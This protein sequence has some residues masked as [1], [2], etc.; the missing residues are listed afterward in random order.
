MSFPL[1]IDRPA[2]AFVADNDSSE[3]DRVRMGPGGPPASKTVHRAD[4]VSSHDIKSSLYRSLG[5]WGSCRGGGA[6]AAAIAR[7]RASAAPDSYGAAR[8]RRPVAGRIGRAEAQTH[9][10]TAAAAEGASQDARLPALESDLQP[11][12][13]AHL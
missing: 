6:G 5:R 9:R 8:D 10:G 13:T 2:R 4:L 3:G 11:Q 12:A 7:R 1:A